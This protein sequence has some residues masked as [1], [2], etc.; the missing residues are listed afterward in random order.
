MALFTFNIKLLINICLGLRQ[1]HHVL[2][3]K[4]KK[5]PQFTGIPFDPYGTVLTA[6]K[7]P[8]PF[9]IALVVC[10]ANPV[11]ITVK[12][13]ASAPMHCNVLV[14]VSTPKVPGRRSGGKADVV[15]EPNITD[16]E[17]REDIAKHIIHNPVLDTLKHMKRS[18]SQVWVNNKR[19]ERW[20]NA[21]YNKKPRYISLKITQSFSLFSNGTDYDPRDDEILSRVVT[22]KNLRRQIAQL[23]SQLN[24]N[25]GERATQLVQQQPIGVVQPTP[26]ASSSRNNDIAQALN[27]LSLQMQQMQQFMIQTRSS[28]SRTGN[29]KE[30]DHFKQKKVEV[31]EWRKGK[32]KRVKFTEEDNGQGL[33]KELPFKDVPPVEFAN[34]KQESATIKDASVKAIVET[35]KSVG[36]PL[37]DMIAAAPAVQKETENLVTKKRVP[38]QAKES[39]HLQESTEDMD[40]YS[41]SEDEDSL[42]GKIFAPEG[43][44]IQS[45]AIHTRE[46]PMTR[47]YYVAKEQDGL[48]P[49]GAIV[50]CDPYLQYLSTLDENEAPRQVF[51]SM[52]DPA[53]GTDSAEDR[54][55]GG[56]R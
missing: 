13:W 21:N 36:I 6:F 24:Q 14:V 47:K 38:V 9:V 11:G 51:A 42:P 20:K 27:A 23:T 17:A 49:K 28:A 29:S 7:S 8:P 39:V 53:K 26:M 1:T 33:R 25:Q 32:D 34:R 46:I 30:K 52:V 55:D 37:K 15:C 50:A 3:E 35:I 22:E 12:Q 31:P 56:P 48:V 44:Y 41:E 4:Q 45:D 19:E 40:D 5:S 54:Q 16:V 2:D 43:Q 10:P 18:S